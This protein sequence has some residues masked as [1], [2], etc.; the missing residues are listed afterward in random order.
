MTYL[1]LLLIFLAV[2]ARS[3]VIH[4]LRRDLPPLKASEVVDADFE[5]LPDDRQD[6]TSSVVDGSALKDSSAPFQ[7]LQSKSILDLTLQ[8][9]NITFPFLDTASQNVLMCKIVV[10]A[11]LNGQTYAVGI[12]AQHG[13]LCVVE[14]GDQSLEY[15]DPDVEESVEILEIMAGALEKYLSP[16][17]KLQRTPRILTIAGDLDQYTD[18][19]S[20]N[21]VSEDITMEKLMEQPDDDFDK[22]FDFFR[23]QLGKEEFDKAL[24][25][26]DQLDPEFEALFDLQ[27]GDDNADDVLPSTEELEK[28]FRA[29]GEDL[30][31]QGVGLKLVGFAVKQEKGPPNVYS[32]VKPLKPLT[33]VARLRQ[34]DQEEDYDVFDLLTPDEERLII[35]RLEQVCRQDLESLGIS[36]G[37]SSSA[38]P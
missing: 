8:D 1:S 21:L 16:E 3:F 7:V 30:T 23:Q 17:L 38:A 10:T 24:Q 5:R 27:E 19:F 33:V 29:L 15:I 14:H 26:V 36:V 2:S 20:D 4:P 13:V 31:H 9:N 28:A 32:L 37:A 22:L 25:E 11:K 35:P 34:S 6:H 18:D 12:P